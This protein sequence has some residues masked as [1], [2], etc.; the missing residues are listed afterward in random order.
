[1]PD[2]EP[3]RESGDQDS[4]FQIDVDSQAEQDSLFRSR[5][6]E[7]SESRKPKPLWKTPT[8]MRLLMLCVLLVGV[9]WGMFKAGNPDSWNWLFQLDPDF[10]QNQ[11]SL[12][13]LLSLVVTTKVSGQTLVKLKV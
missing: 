12:H 13:L 9:I 6:N 2:R 11:K 4:E 5:W 3:N 1:M 10:Q 8:G 7:L